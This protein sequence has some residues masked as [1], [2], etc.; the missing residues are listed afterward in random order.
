MLKNG[1]QSEFRRYA[2]RVNFVFAIRDWLYHVSVMT[3]RYHLLVS[4]LAVVQSVQFAPDPCMRAA[5]RDRMAE[6]E[7]AR[8]IEILA[9]RCGSGVAEGLPL[10][11]EGTSASKEVAHE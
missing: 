6:L 3:P 5:A 2:H 8:A 9:N 7:R 4:E 11:A 10:A 1:S